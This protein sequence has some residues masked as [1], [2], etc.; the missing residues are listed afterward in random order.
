MKRGALAFTSSVLFLA[1]MTSGCAS[2]PPESVTG[3]SIKEYAATDIPADGTA[4]SLT[5]VTKSIE[6]GTLPS[7]VLSG[8]DSRLVS[9]AVDIHASKCMVDQG[10]PAAPIR[11]YDWNDP[12]I[13]AGAGSWHAPRTPEE[14]SELGFRTPRNEE[15]QAV[16]RL[17]AEVASRGSEYQKAYEACRQ[18][19]ID[20]PLFQ[21]SPGLTVPLITDELQQPDLAHAA[22]SWRTCM[23]DLGA[24][25]LSDGTP[26][27]PPSLLER[28]GYSGQVEFED[29]PVSSE[30]IEAATKVAHCD[31]D[32]GYYRLDYDMNWVAQERYIQSHEAQF[33]AILADIQQYEQQLKDYIEANRH[34]I[35]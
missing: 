35:G 5:G 3:V 22:E 31:Y 13:V 4:S 32:S 8:A 1:W 33:K 28:F 24:P 17:V 18:V 20:D 11:S 10:Y 34:L 2:S 23:K 19:S 30:E 9:Y 15:G 14:A 29:A 12:S 16:D 7:G 27:V 26:E 6:D 25:D 21:N